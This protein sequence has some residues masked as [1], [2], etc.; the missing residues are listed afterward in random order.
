MNV[1]ENICFFL[2]VC[3]VDLSIYDEKVCCVL[4]MVELDEFLYCKLVEF[5]GGQCQWVVLVCVIV[6]ELNVFLMDEL[7]F[8]FDVKLCVLI[9]VQIKNF[10]YELVVIIIYV[11][12]DQIEVMIFVDCVV[13]MKQGVVQQVGSLME[14]YDC[15]VN[16]FVVSFIGNFVMNLMD[17]VVE[18]GIF[19][20]E[21]VEVKGFMVFDVKMILGFC[22][23]D[24][25]VV[26]SGG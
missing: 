20:V 21:G 25:E 8:N 7:L 19:K 15:L 5:F 9:C 10:F 1:Y 18:G 24:V 3:G 16:V 2:K 13:V 6:C 14:I 26:E 11:I 22:V 17:G 12:Y 23:E 4:V